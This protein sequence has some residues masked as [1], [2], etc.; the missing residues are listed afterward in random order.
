LF[1]VMSKS[2]A[3]IR[4]SFTGKELHQYVRMRRLT[5]ERIVED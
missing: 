5:P 4:Q 3:E 1:T 2:P